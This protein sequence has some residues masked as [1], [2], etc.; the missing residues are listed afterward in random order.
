MIR[1]ALAVLALVQLPVNAGEYDGSYLCLGKV[2]AVVN[3]RNGIAKGY[4]LRMEPEKYVVRIEGEGGS[5]GEFGYETKES[6][7]DNYSPFHFYTTNYN[8]FAFNPELLTFT[9]SDFGTYFENK[10]LGHTPYIVVGD[11]SKI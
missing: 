6:F 7:T 4:D 11:C 10:N 2:G 5:W 9:R 1:Y 8:Y 3:E